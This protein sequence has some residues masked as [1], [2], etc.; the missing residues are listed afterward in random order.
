VLATLVGCLPI[1]S[2]TRYADILIDRPT[3][4][5]TLSGS[6]RYLA[7]PA[8]EDQTLVVDLASEETCR[9]TTTPV[10]HKTAHITRAVN[11]PGNWRP[12]YTAGLGVTGAALG[13][14]FFADAD[15]LAAKGSLEGQTSTPSDYRGVGVALAAVGAAALAVALVDTVRLEDSEE[16]LGPHRGAPEVT[17]DVCHRRT[18]AKTPLVARAPR[19]EWSVQSATDVQGI[20]RVPLSALPEAAFR[21]TELT[22]VLE[23]EGAAFPVTLP[24]LATSMLLTVL[25]GDSRSRVAID[26]DAARAAVCEAQVSGA[27]ALGVTAATTDRELD[28]VL[29][30]WRLA[31]AA[32]GDKWQ[33]QNDQAYGVFA[34]QVEARQQELARVAEADALEEQRALVVA[35]RERQQ[36]TRAVE[37]ERQQQAR[38][39]ERQHQQQQRAGER[40]RRAAPEA[41][42][43]QAPR[44]LRC[45][46][47]TLSPSCTC[48]GPHR[49]CCSWHGGIAGCE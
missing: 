18:V 42:T 21:G 41:P 26:R 5:E 1:T 9:S 24:K 44:G 36:Q 34:V 16:D 33:P 23:V 6:L 3:V 20:A 43:Y 32:C 10:Y 49:G 12:V 37:R 29:E 39:V 28:R 27:T 15:N 4:V 7:T 35:E 45:R 13:V 2:T 46:D 11:A 47:G 48:G 38:T 14:L 8:V 19:A 30:Q 40:R 22:L 17:D 25:A 31:R